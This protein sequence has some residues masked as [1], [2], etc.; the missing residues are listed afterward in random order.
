MLDVENL[1]CVI[2]QKEKK[3]Q[4]LMTWKKIDNPWTEGANEIEE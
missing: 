4:G 1:M 2:W 3:G